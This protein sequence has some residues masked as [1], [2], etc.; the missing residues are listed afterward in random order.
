[1]CPLY[2]SSHFLSIAISIVDNHYTTLGVPH[3]ATTE[4][5]N[6]VFRKLALQYHP[7]KAGATEETHSQFIKIRAAQEILNDPSSRASYDQSLRLSSQRPTGAPPPSPRGSRPRPQPTRRFRNSQAP[8]GRAEHPD[9]TPFSPSLEVE[10]L[11]QENERRYARL[12]LSLSESLRKL[13]FLAPDY[14]SK[15]H[16]RQLEGVLWTLKK[17]AIFDAAILLAYRKIRDKAWPLYVDALAKGFRK[18]SKKLDEISIIEQ[19]LRI[20]IQKFLDETMDPYGGDIREFLWWIAEMWYEGALEGFDCERG[21]HPVLPGE[22]GYV[23]A[24]EQ[25]LHDAL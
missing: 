22:E 14:L 24:W 3:T 9:A 8:P 12:Q 19:D 21:E 25:A 13:P 16:Q 15:F 10:E 7:D 4:E 11:I 2:P 20:C 1:M 6:R 18:S 17:N 23:S 5:I